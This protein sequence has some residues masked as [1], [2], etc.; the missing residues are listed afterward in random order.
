MWCARSLLQVVDP[1][2][3]EGRTLRQEEVNNRWDLRAPTRA[4]RSSSVLASR[5][6]LVVV[7]VVVLVMRP[8]RI[9]SVCRLMLPLGGGGESSCEKWLFPNFLLR[10]RP[11]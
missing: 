2:N 10:H 1:A 5:L 4:S 6:F 11:G 3:G 9:V 7:V 8:D